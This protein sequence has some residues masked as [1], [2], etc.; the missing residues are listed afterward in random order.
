VA[1]KRMRKENFDQIL[2]I[3]CYSLPKTAQHMMNETQ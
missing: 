3:F 1:D 2:E